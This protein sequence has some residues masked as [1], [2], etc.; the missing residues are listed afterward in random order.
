[1]SFQVLCTLFSCKICEQAFAVIV[2]FKRWTAHREGPQTALA[3]T[4]AVTGGKG[5]SVICGWYIAVVSMCNLETLIYNSMITMI[6]CASI[7]SLS[8]LTKCTENKFLLNETASSTTSLATM[9]DVRKELIGYW[10]KCNSTRL[11]TL[12]CVSNDRKIHKSSL[13]LL[14][15]GLFTSTKL[16]CTLNTLLKIPCEKCSP[17]TFC[18]TV[19][20]LARI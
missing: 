19:F 18:L 12:K 9:Q 13:V 15:S 4:G 3:L 17:I 16:V 5:H 14:L 8:T 1:M 7:Y 2:T 10:Y 11:E 20:L 6:T